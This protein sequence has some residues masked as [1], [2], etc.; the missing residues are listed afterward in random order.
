MM[1][2]VR[3]AGKNQIEFTQPPA[4]LSNQRLKSSESSNKWQFY[5]GLCLMRCE[6]FNSDDILLKPDLSGRNTFVYETRFLLCRDICTWKKENS[7]QDTH[8]DTSNRATAACSSKTFTENYPLIQKAFLR[9][10]K[11][12]TQRTMRDTWQRF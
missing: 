6:A 5:L 11:N 10:E 2:Q 12:V 9:F 8:N 3:Y 4:D 1:A 7:L